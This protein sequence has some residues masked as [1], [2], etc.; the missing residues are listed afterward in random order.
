[1]KVMFRHGPSAQLLAYIA[2]KDLEEE[3]TE[4]RLNGDGNTILTLANGWELELASTFDSL[5]VPC[6]VEARRL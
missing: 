2:K 4:Q 1:M 6:T 5:K 3:I